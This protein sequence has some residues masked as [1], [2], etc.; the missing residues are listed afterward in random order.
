MSGTDVARV[1]TRPASTAPADRVPAVGDSPPTWDRCPSLRY[2]PTPPTP[3]PLLT[4][5]RT[6]AGTD[7]LHAAICLCGARAGVRGPSSRLEP[8]PG[9]TLA[10]AQV[11]CLA[12]Y[13]YLIPPLVLQSAHGATVLPTGLLLVAWY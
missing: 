7:V 5:H 10:L 11:R 6:L 3:S 1:C 2:H 4:Q 13:A 8:R 9:P 12:A